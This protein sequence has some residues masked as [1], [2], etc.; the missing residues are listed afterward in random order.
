MS[1]PLQQPVAQPTLAD[2]NFFGS[3]TNFDGNVGEGMYA[4]PPTDYGVWTY[5][6]V[7]FVIFTIAYAVVRRQFS[8]VTN[9]IN[10]KKAIKKRM[11][12]A[13]GDD[14]DTLGTT[15][16]RRDRK[17]RF[18]E[19]YDPENNIKLDGGNLK[20]EEP[21]PTSSLGKNGEYLP[22]NDEGEDKDKDDGSNPETAEAATGLKSYIGTVKQSMGTSVKYI[23]GQAQ[24]V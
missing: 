7:T 21:K 10:I 11:R 16:H 3:M 4:P 6:A 13:L 22:H 19:D 1:A 24:K 14:P 12:R 9:K 23:K 20:E 2:P 8:S 17:D 5:I 18:V 15:D